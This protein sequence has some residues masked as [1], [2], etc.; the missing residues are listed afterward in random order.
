MSVCAAKELINAAEKD[1]KHDFTSTYTVDPDGTESA[2]A[3]L[4]VLGPGVELGVEQLKICL[5]GD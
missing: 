4:Q 3:Y 1:L 5:V 2:Y